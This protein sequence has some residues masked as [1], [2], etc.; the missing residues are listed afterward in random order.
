[1]ILPVCQSV[2]HQIIKWVQL[3]ELERMW[4]E[5]FV[6]SYYQVCLEKLRAVKKDLKEGSRY[7]CRSSNWVPSEYR[8]EALAKF[9]SVSIDNWA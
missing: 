7:P 1:M 4:K 8:S 9:C 6:A 3:N 2:Q 5:A